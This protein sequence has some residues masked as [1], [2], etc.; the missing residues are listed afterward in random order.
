MSESNYTHLDEVA[1][2]R[3][4]NDQLSQMIEKQRVT[5]QELQKENARLA[6]ERDGLHDKISSL[7]REV[8]RKQR[9]TPLLISPET[10]KEIAEADDA[11][12][13]VD[14]SPSPIERHAQEPISPMP[15]PRS[16]YRS[17]KDNSKPAETVQVAHKEQLQ[18][19]RPKHLNFTV[20][21]TGDH[22]FDAVS[23]T[24]STRSPPGSPAPGPRTPTS[25]RVAIMEKDAQTYAKY[26][27]STLRKEMPPLPRRGKP[28][29]SSPVGDHRA[30]ILPTPSKSSSLLDVGRSARS[31]DSMMPP[32]RAALEHDPT[33]RA[34]SPPLPRTSNYHHHH[35]KVSVESACSLN[36]PGATR[37][38]RESTIFGPR[39][40]YPTLTDFQ[41]TP[42]GASLSLKP[43]VPL[44]QEPED[45]SAT[46]HANADSF[47]NIS[48]ISVKVLGS[49]IKTNDKAKEV[50]SFIIAVGN[51]DEANGGDFK[52]R[53]RVEKHY[54]DFLALDALLK[55]QCDRSLS[56]KIA[57]LPDKAL[58]ATNAPSKVDQRKTPGRKEGYLTKRGKNFG[59]WKTRYFVLNGPVLEY[60][61]SKDGSQ[62]GSIRLTNAQIGRQTA[63]ITQVSDENNVYR[64]A[65]LI[66]EQKRA[67]SS[68]VA[69]HILCADS[70][71]ERDDW[72]D[73]LFQNIVI[74]DIAE[75]K[76]EDKSGSE[77]RKKSEKPRKLSK[78][79]IRAIAAAPISH[80][81]FDQ[82]VDAEKLAGVPTMHLASSSA[83]CLLENSGVPIPGLAPASSASSDSTDSS[84]LSTSLPN[85]TSPISMPGFDPQSHVHP[86]QM[87]TSFDQ[88]HTRNL[89]TPRPTLIRR[90]SMVNLLNVAE[91]EASNTA[92][93]PRIRPGSRSPTPNGGRDSDESVDNILDIPEKKHKNK[94]NRMTFWGKKMFSSSNTA[95]A[96]PNSLNPR[97]A[98][99]ASGAAESA[100]GGTAAGATSGLRSF[101]SRT[102]NESND[103]QGQRGKTSDEVGAVKNRQVFGVPL[104]EAVRVSR[105]R[106]GYELPAIVYR[107]IE[108][109]NAKNAVMEE[110]LYRL[111]G[112]NV[113]MKS[114]KDRFNQEGDVDLLSSKE[115]YDV[116]VIA[117]L[118]KMWLRELPTSVL[119]KEYRVD[120]LHVIDLL[121]RKDR[122]NELGRLVS[123]LPL[124]NYTLLR[125]LTAHLIS[126]VQHSDVNKMNVRNVSIVFS[127]T[128]G[129]PATIFNLFM[130]EFEYI[131]WTNED[132]DPAP[133]M[134]EDD[135]VVK[136]TACND[137]PVSDEQ[138]PE[139]SVPKTLSRK[140]TLKLREEHGRSN[141]NSVNYMDGAPNAIVDLEKN[142]DGPPVLDEDEDV[143]DL[144]LTA[145][146]LEEEDEEENKQMYEKKTA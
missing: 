80:M 47:P 128:L 131:F 95:S 114:L 11:I 77:K 75:N 10:L 143:D 99:S 61:E 66:I 19:Q 104:D 76:K 20:D 46:G 29:P 136:I 113:T 144:T 37:N 126:V 129:I 48:D 9:V 14:G 134:L 54:S 90:S 58:F 79:E 36:V 16:P 57:K 26:H 121:D 30:F 106:E 62:L 140:P 41:E 139:Q 60:Y 64:H 45:I 93:D 17:F 102:S 124:A 116:H 146:D 107:C 50:V 53:W 82:A 108:Y 55:A 123:L 142:I 120:F 52:E 94:A 5:I 51:V 23:P 119:T 72:V 109:L 12:T 130:S 98:T 145:G 24:S 21:S 43:E 78:G 137:M 34:A 35:H 88:Q 125:A 7:E 118:L 105:I 138:E 44:I 22:V 87:R 32:T 85:T 67:G 96:D 65:F 117:G 83:E 73:A 18:H 133:R 101:L 70:D 31:R 38:K 33:M 86:L 122:V 111:S 97:G 103:R 25:P 4:H 59:G 49:Q 132:S 2:L 141:R 127:P 92:V 40:D 42:D 115:E 15:P 100:R 56:N 39:S 68:H 1:R 81:K 63:G 27:Q 71:E 8:S 91:E 84:L 89:Q 74:D 112:R 135:E 3:S 69:R 28:S 13:P 110:G 6:A